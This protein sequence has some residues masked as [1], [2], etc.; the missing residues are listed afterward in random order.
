MGEEGC[1]ITVESIPADGRRALSAEQSVVCLRTIL[2]IPHGVLGLVVEI[3]GLVESSNN[4][5]T[6]TT[7]T[8]GRTDRGHGRLH[9][10]QLLHAGAAPRGGADHVGGPARVPRR[11]RS[12]TP[13]RAGSRASTSPILKTCQAVYRKIYG[14]EPLVTAIHAG[15]ECGIIGERVPGMDMISFGPDVRG[16]HSP[17]ERCYVDSVQRSWEYLKAVLLELSR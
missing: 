2:A 10:A 1:R 4:V 11:S 14:T 13:I 7:E 9:G 3:P 8:L 5:A 17:D 6:V 16:A 15:L 12:A